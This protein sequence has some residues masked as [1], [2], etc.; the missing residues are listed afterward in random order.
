[1]SPSPQTLRILILIIAA[2]V[3]TGLLH[4]GD[5]ISVLMAIIVAAG[6]PPFRWLVQRVF[7]DAGADEALKVVERRLLAAPATRAITLD[8]SEVGEQIQRQ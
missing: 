6:A 5:T 3:S 2:S 1:M 8:R 7:S 4:S